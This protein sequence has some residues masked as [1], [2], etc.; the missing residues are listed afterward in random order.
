MLEA[1]G[2][3]ELP[4]FFGACERLLEPDGIACIQTIAVPDQRY[5]AYRRGHDWIREYIF[6]GAL[7]PSLEAILR[8]TS[9]SSEL[10]LHDAENIGHHYAETL[11]RWRERFLANRDEVRALG[12]DERFVRTWEFYLAFCEAGFRTRAL[13]D[14]QLVLTRPFNDRLPCDPAPRTV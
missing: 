13:Q 10:I 7:I 8:A 5:E 11:R 3:H 6:P 4:V 14:Y 9:R 1:I 2:H 12:Y